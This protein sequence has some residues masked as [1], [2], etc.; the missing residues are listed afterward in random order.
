MDE[1]YPTGPVTEQIRLMTKLQDFRE[2]NLPI[3]ETLTDRELEI[4]ALIGD[5]E[6]NPSIAGKLEVSRITVQNHRAS[7]R[8]K[9]NI[10]NDADY[11]IFALAYDLIQF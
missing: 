4:L 3:F 2:K 11:I 9:L 6:K 7:I 1:F 10:Q 5:G 8:E